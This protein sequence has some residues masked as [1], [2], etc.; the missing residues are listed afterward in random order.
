MQ[1]TSGSPANRPARIRTL[2][3]QNLGIR[4]QGGRTVLLEISDETYYYDRNRPWLID[5]M[6]TNPGEHGPQVNVRLR[7]VMAGPV[8][9]SA[10]IPFA[11]Q[12]I[13]EAWEQHEDKLCVIRQLGLICGIDQQELCDEFDRLLD[14]DWRSEGITT[15]EV[16]LYCKEHQLPYYCVVGG[17]LQEAWTPAV[18][19][20]KAVA[21]C[22]FGGHMY[23]YKSARRISDWT[24]SEGTFGSKLKAEA[25]SQAKPIAE[26]QP[27]NGTPSQGTFYCDD[28]GFVR[29]QLLDG[30]RNPRVTT[31]CLQE[32]GGL[33]YTCIESVD[34]CKGDCNIREMPPYASEIERW[35][36]KL[37]NPVEWCGERLP[38]ITAKGTAAFTHLRASSAESE[39]EGG[40][41]ATTA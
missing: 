22:F 24:S 16:L 17:R 10:F 14:R 32:I 37:G 29:K 33:R 35:L 7:Q 8:I 34:G 40:H 15:D 4:T 19:K 26:W 27:W 20:G 36:T 30:G 18:P 5:E 9:A 1:S 21:F 25:R 12:V 2:V 13:P 41:T 11:D 31:R 39:R 6:D 38:A 28:I 23:T 3:L